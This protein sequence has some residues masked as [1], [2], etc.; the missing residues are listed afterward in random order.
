MDKHQTHQR[1][2]I[3]FTVRNALALISCCEHFVTREM[4]EESEEQEG[5]NTKF[6]FLPKL[7][8][9]KVIDWLNKKGSQKM[10]SVDVIQMQQGSNS[11]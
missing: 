11:F 7:T 9:P 10:V 3:Y 6:N 2:Q 8:I 4:V 1:G 5:E